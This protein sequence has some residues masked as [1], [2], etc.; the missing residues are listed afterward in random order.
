MPYGLAV[1]AQW[2][3]W[4]ATRYVE[5]Y[6]VPLEGPAAVALAARKHADD[7]VEAGRAQN[8]A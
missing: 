6:K 2:F 7:S 5:Q 3:A 4:L 1:P 8:H